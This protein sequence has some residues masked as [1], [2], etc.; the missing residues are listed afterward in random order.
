[1]SLNSVVFRGEWS[2]SRSSRLV[3]RE[4]HL[5]PL[6]VKEGEFQSR[7]GSCGEGK[8]VSPF[9]E[10]NPDLLIFYPFV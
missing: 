3:L 4:S 9:R 7:S 5:Y 10:S 1:M 6:Y 8:D 2:D